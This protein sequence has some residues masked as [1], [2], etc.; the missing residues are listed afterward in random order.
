MFWSKAELRPIA[1]RGSHEQSDDTGDLETSHKK[2]HKMKASLLRDD[3]VD[4]LAMNVGQAEV[5]SGVPIRKSLMIKPHQMQD[6][7]V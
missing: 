5:T 3:I 6:G 4:N 7:S 1:T 2:H